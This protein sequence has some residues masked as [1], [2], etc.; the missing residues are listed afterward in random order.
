M[1]EEKEALIAELIELMEK[2]IGNDREFFRRYNPILHAMTK[3][4]LKEELILVKKEQK[5]VK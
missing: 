2:E 5:N 1:N 4:E 3:E